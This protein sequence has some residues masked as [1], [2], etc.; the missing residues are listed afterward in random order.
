MG[1]DF[2]ARDSGVD[3]C[4]RG[5]VYFVLYCTIGNDGIV[6][7]LV[8]GDSDRVEIV[9]VF[10]DESEASGVLLSFVFLNEDGSVDSSKC[11]LLVLDNS[12]GLHYVPLEV[13][14]GQYMIH[15]YDIGANGMLSGTTV[16]SPA[17]T[18]KL[19]ATEDGTGGE[20]PFS[21]KFLSKK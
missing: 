1:C 16:L 17:L 11:A 18:D 6:A 4:G 13:H 14:H 21:Y 5:C 12:Q 3:R 2:I 7:A 15:M 19:Y 20:L 8:L 10:C 9:T